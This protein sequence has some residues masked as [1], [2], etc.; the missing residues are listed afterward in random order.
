[1]F[2]AFISLSI[3]KLLFHHFSSLIGDGVKVHDKKSAG[4]IEL[5]TANKI[6]TFF[7]PWDIYSQIQHMNPHISKHIPLF[8]H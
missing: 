4:D 5:P 7:I 6:S 2:S 1:M 3:L 8:D